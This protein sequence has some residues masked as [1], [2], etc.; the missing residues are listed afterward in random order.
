MPESIGGRWQRDPAGQV[1]SIELLGSGGSCEDTVGYLGC[2]HASP[3]DLDGISNG[4]EEE[5]DDWPE[6]EEE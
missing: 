3:R 6:Q 2:G 5:A 4:E 1:G